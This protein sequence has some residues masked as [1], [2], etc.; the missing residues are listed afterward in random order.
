[1]SD[2]ETGTVKWFNNSKGFG[3]IKREQGDDVFVHYR[4]IRGDGYRSLT[5][6]QTVEFTITQ[7]QK[8][9]AAEDVA[10]VE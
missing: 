7:G 3:F 8:G 4:A 6:G 1:M 9:F 5:Q 2:R 10:V